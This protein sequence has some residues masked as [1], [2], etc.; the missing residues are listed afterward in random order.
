MQNCPAYE[1]DSAPRKSNFGASPFHKPF[2]SETT[3]LSI[4]CLLLVSFDTLS[5]IISLFQWFK[6]HSRVGT[7]AHSTW[8]FCWSSSVLKCFTIA[9]FKLFAQCCSASLAR[10]CSA[11]MR[12]ARPPRTYF[13]LNLETERKKSHRPFRG[14]RINQCAQ[15][16]LKVHLLN[17]ENN[18]GTG[19][20]HCFNWQ[21]R[22]GFSCR[23]ALYAEID[24]VELLRL[25]YCVRCRA[26]GSCYGHV[27]TW[28]FF[29]ILPCVSTVQY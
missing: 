12:S 18:S 1:D 20:G 8:H 26:H 17:C 10:R 6:A 23:M 21:R 24:I 4:S 14:K 7:C 15:N 16:Y 5:Y 19:V 3:P 13:S 27:N 11:R 22:H 2:R 9:G 28:K 25:M 29:T